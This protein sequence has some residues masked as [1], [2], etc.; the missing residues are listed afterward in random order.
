[1]PHLVLM[2]LG[3]LDKNGAACAPNIH[4]Y[5]PR[6]GSWTK[7]DPHAMRVEG[8]EYLSGDWSGCHPVWTHARCLLHGTREHAALVAFELDDKS[9]G[10]APGSKIDIIQNGPG[11][12]ADRLWPEERT[13]VASSFFPVQDDAFFASFHSEMTV[14]A[15]MF[16]FGGYKHNARE[17][18][19][20][21]G[22]RLLSLQ[23]APARTEVFDLFSYFCACSLLYFL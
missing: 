17:A 13:R 23:L 7:Q 6:M 10:I 11:A 19:C 22:A 8:A 5:D 20:S 12:A 14:P 2:Q 9:G 16:V 3:G 21:N 1:M 4:V 18:V 15:S